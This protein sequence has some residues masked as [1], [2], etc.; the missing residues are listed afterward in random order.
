MPNHSILLLLGGMKSKDVIN[1]VMSI[2]K[3]D[4]PPID[5]ISNHQH[6]HIE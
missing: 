1:D 4:L 3:K 2:L 6:A 5:K